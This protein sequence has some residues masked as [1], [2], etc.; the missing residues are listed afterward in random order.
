MRN[1]LKQRQTP[2]FSARPLQRKPLSFERGGGVRQKARGNYHIPQDDDEAGLSGSPPPTGH[3]D[4]GL[5]NNI[6]ALLKYIKLSNYRGLLGAKLVAAIPLFLNKRRQSPMS[7]IVMAAR[8]CDFKA[9]LEADVR[10]PRFLEA[11][12]SGA[13]RTVACCRGVE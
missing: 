7:S 8:V 10:W 9:L 13:K 3:A 6:G 4:G 2:L 5:L 11:A 1:N 12:A